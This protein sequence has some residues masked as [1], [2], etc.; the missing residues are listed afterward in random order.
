MRVVDKLSK[1]FGGTGKTS[2]SLPGEEVV[3]IETTEVLSIS[4]TN[5]WDFWVGNNTGGRISSAFIAVTFGIVGSILPLSLALSSAIFGLGITLL[6][7]VSP[8]FLL[9]GT[10]GGKGQ[11][12]FAGWLSALANTV[13]K[14]IAVSFLL[15]VSIA[16]TLGIM[17]LI[18][19]LGTI[20]SFVLLVLVSLI[21][22]KNKNMLLDKFATIDF[23]GAFDPRTGFNQAVK[24]QNDRAKKVGN[25]ASA[26]AAG[27][28]TNKRIGG[29]FKDGA[30]QG[31]GIQMR[32]QLFQSEMGRNITREYDI[33]TN[34]HGAEGGHFCIV[35]HSDL[36]QVPG[37]LVYRDEPGN[38]YCDACANEMGTEELYAIVVDG[39]EVNRNAESY[40]F[41][42]MRSENATTNKSWVSY[43]NAKAQMM[44]NVDENLKATWNDDGVKNMAK[45]S[46]NN[47][48][49]DI[50]VFKENSQDLGI[51]AKPPTIPEPLHDY[52][53]L[54]TMNS[55]WSEKDF[56]YVRGVYKEAWKSWYEDNAK[57]IDGID[58]K[59]IGKFLTDID[60]MKIKINH[61]DV[62][63][64]LETFE[65]KK[66]KSKETDDSMSGRD[67]DK[68]VYRKSQGNMEINTELKFE[69]LDSRDRKENTDKVD[70]RR[71]LDSEKDEVPKGKTSE[72]TLKKTK[73]KKE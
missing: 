36:S 67:F 69:D 56:D 20:P 2:S 39:G 29:S 47:L 26:S 46:I 45:T 14:K 44:I 52:I 57:Q 62:A 4:P 12:I 63:E 55:A 37:S 25:L 10:W 5:A 50:A 58:E 65:S 23:G 17:S 16:F 64:A 18:A 8:V 7:M 31:F 54:A 60:N 49:T 33:K 27:A 66:R 48:E 73:S 15:I 53:D 41:S 19:E 3:E 13:L 32:N 71:G 1:L 9:F 42:T 35:C 34:A 28:I 6:T 70:K 21:I 30:K 43:G 68:S 24:K 51:K 38:Y 59:E 40:D 61:L 22:R 11:K 72:D